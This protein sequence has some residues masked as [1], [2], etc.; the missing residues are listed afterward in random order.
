MKLARMLLL[1]VV[2]VFMAKTSMAALIDLGEIIVD[3]G[4]SIDVSVSPFTFNDGDTVEADLIFRDHQHIEL[5]SAPSFEIIF[6]TLTYWNDYSILKEEQPAAGR[7]LLMY[8]DEQG[9][10]Q[11]DPTANLENQSADTVLKV[12]QQQNI[13]QSLKYFKIRPLAGAGYL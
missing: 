1:V 2:G 5:F 12:I 7:T 13:Q 9:N 3:A 11:F 8:T 10:L 6:L 4:K